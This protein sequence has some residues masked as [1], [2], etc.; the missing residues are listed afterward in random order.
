MS[1]IY[2]MNATFIQ[3]TDPGA[4]TEEDQNVMEIEIVDHGDG[5]QVILRTERW[6][7]DGKDDMQRFVEVLGE[8]MDKVQETR[9]SRNN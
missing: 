3:P 7:L 5:P 2:S 1:E 6:S 9:I 4:D 8:L